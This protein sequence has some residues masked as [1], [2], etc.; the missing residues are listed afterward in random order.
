MTSLQARAFRART[1]KPRRPA[2]AA[3]RQACLSAALS[4]RLFGDGAADGDVSRRRIHSDEIRRHDPGQAAA[5]C[6]AAG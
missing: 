6:D 5:C 3:V 4:R 2:L 1:P